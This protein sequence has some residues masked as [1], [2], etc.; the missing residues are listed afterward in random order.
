M[1]KL[2]TRD[3]FAFARVIK[4]SGMRNELKNLIT[5]IDTTKELDYKQIGID[6]F[7]LIIEA[8][9]E[10]KSENAI[11][12]ALAAPMEI[13][14]KDL[15]EMPLDELF[16]KLKEMAESIDFKSFFGYVSALVGKN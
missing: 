12:E 2:Q 4:A 15:A 1:R 16:A 8:L 10:K 7:L 3:I 6:G 9:A 14:A 11:Y 5:S 13:K